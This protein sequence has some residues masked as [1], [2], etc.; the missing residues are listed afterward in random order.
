[1]ADDFDAEL[2]RSHEFDKGTTHR[3]VDFGILAVTNFMN[4]FD[5]TGSLTA[6]RLAFGTWDI[7]MMDNKWYCTFTE[8]RDIL[9]AK[10]LHDKSPKRARPQNA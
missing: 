5:P 1:M 3:L 2:M 6:S 7:R 4:F 9:R 10:G 8:A